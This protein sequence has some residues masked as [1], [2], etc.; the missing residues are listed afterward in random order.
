MAASSGPDPVGYRC[1]EVLDQ[2]Q[3]RVLA[4]SRGSPW[5]GGGPR[6]KQFDVVVLGGGSAAE[7]VVAGLDGGSV[8]VVES[9]W[10]GGECPFVACIPSKAMLRSAHLRRLIETLRDLGA[11]SS[12]HTSGDGRE[13]YLVAAARRDRICDG[14]DDSQHAADLLKMGAEL[15]RGR[16]RLSGERTVTVT[17]DGGSETH[18]VFRQLVIATGSRPV[19]P[20]IH[21]LAGLP[22]WT[23]DQ[24]LASSEL[25]ARLVILGGGPIGCELSQVYASFGSLVTMVEAEPRLLP[26]EEPDLGA[27]L[28]REMDRVGVKVILG[29]KVLRAVPDDHGASIELEGGA[30][31]SCDRVLLATG[32]RANL[33]EIGLEWLGLDPG[34]AAIAV[35]QHCRVRGLGHVW[36]AGDVTGVA[37]FTHTANYQGWIVARNLRGRATRADYRAIPRVVYTDPP[38][39][40]VGLTAAAAR[41]QGMQVVL[42]SAT[43]GD[44]SRALVDGGASGQ[45]TALA[46]AK[47]GVLVGAW[48]MGPGADERISEL[49]MAIRCEIPLVDLLDVVHPFPTFSE[50][51]DDLYRGLAAEMEKQ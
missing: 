1:W 2:R 25:P 38:V 30:T 45:V 5:I 18:L 17:D 3:R 36:A 27:A 4:I 35:D 10:V 39:A 11:T 48:A 50:A 8:A 21:G 20:P 14:R 29:S 32:R 23:S 24:A 49:S 22:T 15:Y 13:A 28:G 9:A 47:R 7:M 16:G 44:T 46:D 31:I 6:V 33:D 42:A 12:I 37:P 40:C 26:S 43:F 51:H 34:S 41:E 19:V